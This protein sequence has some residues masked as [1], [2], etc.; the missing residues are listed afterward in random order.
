MIVVVKSAG[1]LATMREAG[2][3]V[4]TTLAA[5]AAA[6]V[7]GCRL[8]D[9]DDLAADRI[10]AAGAKSS[11]LGYHPDWAPVPYPAVLCLSVDDAIVHAI[12][13]GRRLRAGELLSIDFAVQYD[14][15][16]ADAA[17]TVPVADVDDAGRQLIDTTARALDAGIAT[18]RP[19]SR[20]GDIGYAVQS[21]A[22]AAG[23]GQPVGLG[24][25]GIGT[26]MHEDP[27]VS[28]TGRPGRGLPLR[29]GL[30]LAI[31][32]M[33]TEGGRND[34]RTGADGWTVSTVDGSRA[35]H[36]EHTVAVTEDGP[37]VLTR[38]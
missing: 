34:H 19:G 16:H 38:P 24:G 17:I 3:I 35:A 15:L 5:V 14:G 18:A 29:P 32:P 25:H 33:L 1:E 8:L 13:D 12:P 31:E 20:L 7:P 10:A 26:E 21:V 27:S 30:V 9:L 37:V 4:A 28:N 6:A 23:Y 36:F 2:R 11:F 22:R